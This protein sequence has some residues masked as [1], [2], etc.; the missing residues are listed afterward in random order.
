MQVGADEQATI[1]KLVKDAQ[2][3]DTVALAALYE[4]FFDRIY[5]YVSFKSGSHDEAEDIA[6]DVFVKMLESIHSFRWQ[7]HPF[8]SWLF[9]IAHNMIVDYFRRA[10]RK[11]TVPLEAAAATVGTTPDDMDRAVATH[12]TM[13]EVTVAM[14]GLTGLQQ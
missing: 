11:K 3:G 2:K 8:S 13:A 6:G 1:E 14:H 12:L 5:R 7:G 10:G 4:R 9:R